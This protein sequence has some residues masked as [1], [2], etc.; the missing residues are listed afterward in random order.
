MD[1]SADVAVETIDEG[2]E[3]A[4]WV[5]EIDLYDREAQEWIAAS[6][7]ILRRYKANRNVNEIKASRFNILWS[8]VQTLLPALYAKNPKPDIERRFKDDDDLGR[9]ASDVLERSI[10][11]FVASHK[12]GSC[13]RQV[14]LD[15]LLPGRGTAWVR[16]VPHFRDASV[17]GNPEVK[18]EGAQ[19]TEDVYSEE[20]EGPLQEVHYEEVCFDYVHWQDFGHPICRTWEEN[21]AVW[22][23]VYLTRDELIERFGEEIGKAV[24]LDYT[25]RGLNDEKVGEHLKKATVYEIWDKPNK[26]VIWLHKDHSALLDRRDDPLRLTEFFPCPEPLYATLAN[27]SLIPTPDYKEY[28][29]Q[30]M[31]LDNLTGR[32]NE[33][34]K[35]LKVAGVYDS[36]ASGV[37]R[38][39]SEGI[40]NQLIPVDQ[41]AAY[42]EKG[43][44]K[45][46]IELLP[47]LEIAQTLITLFETR[48]KIKQDLYEITGLSDILRGASNPNETATAQNIKGQFATL[49]LSSMQE[50][51]QRF[52]RDLVVIATQVI[53]QHFAVDTLKKISGVKLLTQQ[54][55]AQFQMQQ[56]QQAMQAQ[57]MAQQAQV[58]Q[59]PGQPPAPSPPPPPEVP[60][61]M[62]ELMAN[63]TW[64][65]LEALFRDEAMLGFR[66]DIETDS[67]IKTDEE[68][69]K[70]ARTEFLQM[71]TGFMQQMAQVQNPDMAALMGK[72][73]L[74]GVRGFKIGKDLESTFKIAISKLEKA[75]KEP[76]QPPP[77]PEMAKAN[78]QIQ[79]MQQQQQLAQQESQAKGQMEQQKNEQD[80]NKS[81]MEMQLKQEQ[82]KGEFELEA[83]K[84]QSEMQLKE[85]IEMLRLMMEARMN[86]AHNDME[87]ERMARDGVEK[88]QQ[89]AESSK[90]DI[91][92]LM[93]PITEAMKAFGEYVKAPRKI[94]AIGSS[95]QKIEGEI[96]SE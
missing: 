6:K 55:K 50:A 63:P 4:R 41:W 77:D 89:A 75:A 25:P 88:R 58:Q 45:G 39:L 85:R 34:Q 54:E 68:A 7:K 51:V 33:I 35:A 91:G 2:G 17:E 5:A 32:I 73:L 48:D 92:A 86:D 47:M 60:E 23:R 46:A 21:R 56:Q 20:D 65:E 80:R 79:M 95:G 96:R 53:A 26:K 52:A 74:F 66:I 42:G 62:Q 44:L 81:I 84:Q 78:A 90:P 40:Q 22:R 76:K 83:Q 10:G 14:V 29:D 94:T 13:M 71:A 37:E 3:H 19:T 82:M 70:K 31:E 27:D 64:E 18:A 16:Y 72:M 38:L 28:E 8:N 11:Y 43:G 1:T 9:V 59:Q 15:R 57:Q 93:A 67:T 87:V 24:P 12:F 30:A 61:E 36:A 69:E 49:R